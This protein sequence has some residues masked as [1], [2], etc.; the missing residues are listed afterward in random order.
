MLF[1]RSYHTHYDDKILIDKIIFMKLINFLVDG[2]KSRSFN[3]KITDLAVILMFF[4]IAPLIIYVNVFSANETAYP[5]ISIISNYIL[6]ITIVVIISMFKIT[7]YKVK[8]VLLL[9]V[10]YYFGIKAMLLGNLEFVYTISVLLIIYT[11]LTSSTKVSVIVVITLVVMYLC[12]PILTYFNIIS[13]YY[14]PV[15]FHTGIKFLTIRALEGVMSLLFMSGMIYFVFRN[16]K[17]NIELL[18]KRVSETN[19][20]NT[21]LIHEVAIRKKAELSAAQHANNFR[22][23]YNNSYDGY[24]I[25][26]ED[27]LIT[28]VN[29]TVLKMTGY[30][31]GEIVGYSI[32]SF[33]DEGYK[34]AIEDR[35]QQ[36]GKG[37]DLSELM[38]DTKN[39]IGDRLI[40]LIQVVFI[41]QN[42]D[43]TY[44]V[45]LKDV[46]KQNIALEKLYK[47]EEMH[48]S[49]FEQTNDSILIMNDDR[50]VDYNLMAQKLY[51]NI[52]RDHYH[53]PY[54]N[55][56]SLFFDANPMVNLAERV[57]LALHKEIQIFEWIHNLPE[58]SS[59]IHT[60]VNIKALKELGPKYY[61]VVEKDITE[62][63][64][65]QNLILNSIIQTEENERKRISSDLHDGLGPLLTT[66]KLYTQALVDEENAQKQDIIK[67]KLLHL[68]EEA[69]NS[70]YDIAFNISPSILVNYGIVEAV[71][72]FI[73]RLSL[74]RDLTI[75]FN[76]NHI[77]RFSENKEITIYRLFT[78][79]VNNTL[80]H[81]DATVVNFNM[82]ESENN[83]K[84]LYKDNGVGFNIEKVNSAKSGMGL[85]NLRNRIL[86]FNGR[87]KIKS[88]PNNGVE[89]NITIPKIDYV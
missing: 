68:V 24:M 35:K 9:T 81:A 7:P 78:E 19:L 62:R 48:R 29:E 16:N 4:L 21:S 37:E 54:V 22:T 26:S 25:C 32:F 57:Q 49:L 66:I 88:Q 36:R 55:I 41:K 39:K 56:S 69:V 42:F 59:S 73:E 15:T 44:L 86:S 53:I 11:L 80:K 84:L 18:K 43:H 31:K 6:L 72:T 64:R 2:K 65:N 82:E 70:A 67:G 79:L 52:K 30:K 61:M 58:H 51:P 45:V 85:S 20:L 5:T 13:F 23:L 8:R 33:I 34:S 63:K 3:Q 1:Y 60:L 17:N 46:T 89:V 83:I 14:D 71:E 12:V 28:E 74:K 38:I 50:L 75:K 87:F 76:H 10:M 77:S 47:S 27:Y 40:F